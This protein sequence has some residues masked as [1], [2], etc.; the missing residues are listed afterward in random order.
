METYDLL[1][2]YRDGHRHVVKDVTNYKILSNAAVDC[3]M[4]EKNGCKS[5]VPLDAI[6]FMGR[7][8]DYENVET[9]SCYDCKWECLDGCSLRRDENG[10]RKPVYDDL[11]TCNKFKK[12]TEE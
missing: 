7:R 2:I 5:F 10:N 8:I 11:T 1:I 4:Y 9:H 6:S 12:K 3:A